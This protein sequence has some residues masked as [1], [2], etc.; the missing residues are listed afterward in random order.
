MDSGEL[1]GGAELW[2]PDQGLH[3]LGSKTR[4][5]NLNDLLGTCDLTQANENHSLAL[6]WIIGEEISFPLKFLNFV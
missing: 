5:E 6:A 3:L 1:G 2:G 4:S